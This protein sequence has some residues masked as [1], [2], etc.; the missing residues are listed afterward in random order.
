M[1]MHIYQPGKDEQTFC[2]DGYQFPS[3][4][5]DWQ[6]FLQAFGFSLLSVTLQLLYLSLCN[7]NIADAVNPLRGSTR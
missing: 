6:S 5:C 1:R 2:I 3:S 4:S 7:Q